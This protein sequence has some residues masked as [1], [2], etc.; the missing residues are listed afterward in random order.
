MKKPARLAKT[1][2]TA[3]PGP[4]PRRRLDPPARLLLVTTAL[5]AALEV[6]LPPFKGD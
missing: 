1:V 5:F 6:K 2:A 3:D 4:K